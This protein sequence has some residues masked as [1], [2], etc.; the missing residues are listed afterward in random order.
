VRIIDNN[1]NETHEKELVF[2]YWLSKF[3]ICIE[4]AEAD[5]NDDILKDAGQVQSGVSSA[6]DTFGVT[7][8]AGVGNRRIALHKGVRVL[9]EFSGHKNDHLESSLDYD[10]QGNRE[11]EG[12]FEQAHVWG[13]WR[14]L[15]VRFG[16]T[17]EDREW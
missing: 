11:Q 15:V 8:V 9:H 16:P 12:S 13:V 6:R 14:Q 3:P 7:S 1:N 2:V 5:A 4:D 17:H 10:S